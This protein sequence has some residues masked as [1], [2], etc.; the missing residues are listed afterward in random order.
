MTS[1]HTAIIGDLWPIVVFV[2]GTIAATGWIYWIVKRLEKVIFP[3]DAADRL[4]TVAECKERQGECK[5]CNHDLFE[6]I[7]EKL[8]ENSNILCDIRVSV[9]V[10]TERLKDN[11]KSV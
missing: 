4:L 11:A 1:E 5:K 8:D 2:I 6:K 7:T 10:L 3:A 9:G